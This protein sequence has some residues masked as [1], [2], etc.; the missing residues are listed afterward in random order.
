M[1]PKEVRR[2]LLFGGTL[3]LG[4]S[5]RAAAADIS[6]AVNIAPEARVPGRE[7]SVYEIRPWIDGPVLGV[8]A[9]GASVPVLLQSH[10][11]HKRCPCDPED[12]NSFDRP[13]I[14]NHSRLASYTSH[15]TVALAIAT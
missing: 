1:S 3:L 12:V 5:L 13:V 4:L 8:A 14:G 15:V 10:I 9:L 2:I 7:L 6:E 11:V